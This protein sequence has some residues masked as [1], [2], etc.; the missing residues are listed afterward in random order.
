MLNIK[1]DKQSGVPAYRQVSLQIHD[2]IDQNVLLAGAKLPPE[3]ELAVSL[4]VARGTIKRAYEMLVNENVLT[5]IQG[6]G[7][8]V[9]ERST[10][11]A[12]GR[13]TAATIAIE[14]L[15]LQLEQLKFSH[16]EIVALVELKLREREEQLQN[17][18]VAAIDCNPETLAIFDRQLAHLCQVRLAK[19]LLSDLFETPAPEE[20]MKHF[21]LILTTS[22]HYGELLELL[23]TLKNRLVQVAVS[24]CEKTIIELAGLSKMQRMGVMCK[25]Q[26]FRRIVQNRLKNFDLIRD[27]IPWLQIKNRRELPDFLANLDVI[28]VPPDYQIQ[29]LRETVYAVQAFTERGGKVIVFDYQMERGSLLRVEERVQRVLNR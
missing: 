23:P 14:K 13:K 10:P 6:S 5:A 17:L 18:H 26:N 8:F 12:T 27:E 15:I 25:S 22:T 29:R 20:R 21:D 9:A 28:F 4:K 24:P 2:L 1:V 16:G 19:V 11:V 3:R 7:T